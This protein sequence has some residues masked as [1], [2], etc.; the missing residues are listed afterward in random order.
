[1][2]PKEG[3]GQEIWWGRKATKLKWKKKWKGLAH[4]GEE[5]LEWNGRMNML[6]E[7]EK[8]EDCAGTR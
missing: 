1:M 4:A 8:K 3:L 7:K 2:K 6:N 5:R